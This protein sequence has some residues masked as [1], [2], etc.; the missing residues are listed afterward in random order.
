[1]KYSSD[2]IDDLIARVLAGEAS[3]EEVDALEGWLNESPENKRYFDE[4]KKVFTKIEGFKTEYKV[5]S[6]KAWEKLNTRITKAE[7]KVEARVVPLFSRR[8]ILRAAAS[9]LII[10]ALAV[11]VNYIFDNKVAEPVILSANKKVIEQKLPDGSKVFLNKNSEIAYVVNKKNIREVKLKG[12][13][14]FEV[15]HNEEQPFEIVID[16]VVI[17]DIGTTFN[18]KALPESNTIEVLVE[19]GEVQFYSN[20][21]KG[22]TIVKGEKA[23]YDKANKQFTKVVPS[24][25]ENTISYKSHVFHFY[26]SSLREVVQQVNDVYGSHIRLNDERLGNCRVSVVFNNENLDMLVS[27][28]AETL[29]LEVQRLQDTIVLKGQPCMK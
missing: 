29:D 21:N 13:A 1:M 10:A 28:I 22:L 20:S 24:P 14:Y 3:R 5:D 7:V 18:V 16:E 17:K 15:V 4:S 2:N 23:L 19:S 12:E 8:G 25:V 27:I 9:L 11:L 6:L 26:E